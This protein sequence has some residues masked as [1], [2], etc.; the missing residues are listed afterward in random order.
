MIR[1]RDRHN[2]LASRRNESPLPE[3]DMG[4]LGPALSCLRFA[5]VVRRANRGRAS[6]RHA[7]LDGR[8][9]CRCAA[10]ARHARIR[11]LD[12]GARPGSGEA[13]NRSIKDRS[14]KDRATQQ[15]RSVSIVPTLRWRLQFANQPADIAGLHW[16]RRYRDFF[17]V[18]APGA[19]ERAKFKSSGPRRDAR[20]RH[21][22]LALWAAKSLNGK[23]RDYGWIIGHG[24]HLGS[25]EST[26]LSVTGRCRLGTVMRQHCSSGF[27]RRWSQLV[28]S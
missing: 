27:R 13:Q 3:S 4:P 15:N 25:G 5:V 28:S 22:R 7:A 9:A 20:K 6:G 11:C 8:R 24:L 19:I 23:Q 16:I 2:A 10:A 14:I 1:R 21:A 26:K 18:I 17:D 12:G